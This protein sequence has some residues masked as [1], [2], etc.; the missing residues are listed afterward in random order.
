MVHPHMQ[1]SSVNILIWGLDQDS[2]FGAE[3]SQ[4]RQEH[5]I[6][7]VEKNQ[8]IKVMNLALQVV[9]CRHNRL[10]SAITIMSY[11]TLQK[12]TESVEDDDACLCPFQFAAL[13]DEN[14]TT[15][16]AIRTRSRSEPDSIRARPGIH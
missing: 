3:L 9:H 10:C 11:I 12:R 6:G 1:L 5:N 16:S 14:K 2:K 15:Q 4:V 13:N 8:T 7:T